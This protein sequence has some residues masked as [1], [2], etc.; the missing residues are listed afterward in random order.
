M[1]NKIKFLLFLAALVLIGYLGSKIRIDT[2][3]I[4]NSLCL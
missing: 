4:Q 1:N 2:S 3:A